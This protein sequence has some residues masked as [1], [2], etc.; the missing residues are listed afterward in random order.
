MSKA[1]IPHLEKT[2][3]TIINM[4]SLAGLRPLHYALPYSM[5]K[6]MVD[7][8]TQATA[9]ALGAKGIR[10]NSIKW[11]FIQHSW[12][13]IVCPIW[14]MLTLL[15]LIFQFLVLPQWKQPCL[16]NPMDLVEIQKEWRRYMFVAN[17]NF[18]RQFNNKIHAIILMLI[19]CSIWTGA[20]QPSHSGALGKLLKLLVWQHSLDRRKLISSQEP[21]SQL[22]VPILIHLIFQNL[23]IRFNCYI[24]NIKFKVIKLFEP[25]KLSFCYLIA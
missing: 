25:T 16:T 20:V 22:M 23:N 12:M 3:G 17:M 9:V 15:C 7:R 1:A 13:C 19:T 4:S 5:C 11:V 10:I 6:C 8:F 21:H 14:L 2:K 24:M 18:I